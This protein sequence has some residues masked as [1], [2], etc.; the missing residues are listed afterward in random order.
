MPRLILASTSKYRRALLE[1]LGAVR[2][3]GARRRRVDR[4]GGWRPPRQ[5]VEL[6]ATEGRGRER[7]SLKPSSSAAIRPRCSTERCWASLAAKRTPSPLQRLSGRQHQLITVAVVHPGGAARFTDVTNLV[8]RR[9][10]D[11]RS[12]A[13]CGEQPLDCA[14]SYKI[15]SHGEA[16]FERVETRDATAIMGLPLA[17][18]CTTLRALGFECSTSSSLG[19]DFP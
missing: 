1:Q 18:L 4:Q 6:L 2:G 17:R 9:P 13:T 10:R 15:E 16:L 7:G 5:I 8:M 11:G 19:F 12:P 3:R 14:G